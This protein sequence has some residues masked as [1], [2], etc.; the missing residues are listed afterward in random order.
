MYISETFR[1]QNVPG[2]SGILFHV[3]NTAEDTEGCILLG[4]KLGQA[5][6]IPGIAESKIG[7]MKFMT[8]TRD[9]DSFELCISH[10]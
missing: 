3:G 10:A 9:W 5:I 1:V 8:L 7:F 6:N 2:R 4:L